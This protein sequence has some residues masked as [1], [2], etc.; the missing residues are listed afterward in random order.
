MI[1]CITGTNTDVGKTIATAAIAAQLKAAGKHVIV[2]KPVQTGEPAGL[3]DAPTI[4]RLAGVE[5]REFVRYPEPLA[6]QP[7]GPAR[8]NAPARP[9]R[10]R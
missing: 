7:V 10:T 4:S 3:G 1:I 8:G 5:T 9:Q 2:A 6:P